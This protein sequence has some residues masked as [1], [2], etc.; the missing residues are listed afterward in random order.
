MDAN[1]DPAVEP[2][3]RLGS[4][5]FKAGMITAEQLREALG[6]QAREAMDGKLPRQIGIIL[7]TKGY[8]M[9]EQLAQ[10]L[11]NQKAL[12]QRVP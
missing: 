9:P 12:R 2:D 3:I 8:L 1:P 4:L 7:M 6:A 11:Q 10:L 5:A